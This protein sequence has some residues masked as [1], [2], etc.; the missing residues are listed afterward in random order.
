MIYLIFFLILILLF[1]F[2]FLKNKEIKDKYY[3]SKYLKRDY[4]DLKK[5]IPEKIIFSN[6]SINFLLF[7]LYKNNMTNDLHYILKFVFYDKDT[8][9]INKLLINK[10]DFF[11]YDMKIKKDVELVHQHQQ[12]HN[13]YVAYWQNY[14]KNINY[15]IIKEK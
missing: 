4:I 14:V 11:N 9:F 12:I 10:T 8:S 15:D 7:Y 6:E 2:L 3:F 13:Q 1:S 5:K